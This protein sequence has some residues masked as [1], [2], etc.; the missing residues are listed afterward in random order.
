MDAT[1]LK[2]VKVSKYILGQFGYAQSLSKRSVGLV[3]T[4]NIINYLSYLPDPSPRGLK[5]D[6]E[7]SSTFLPL[8]L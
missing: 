8:M 1:L 5:V 2:I 6:L 7:G 4:G 3:Y